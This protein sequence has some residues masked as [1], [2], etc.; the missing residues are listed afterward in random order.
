MQT[1]WSQRARPGASNIDRGVA[2]PLEDMVLLSNTVAANPWFCI[3]YAAV[4]VC[5]C[6]CVCVCVVLG[7]GRGE[8]EEEEG[9]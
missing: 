8:E 6:V 5:V 3:P 9:G 4:S 1:E 7:G 2:L